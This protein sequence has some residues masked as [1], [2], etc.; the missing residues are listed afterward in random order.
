M[1]SVK[2][3]QL[4]SPI[5]CDEKYD[6]CHTVWHHCECAHCTNPFAT[7]LLWTHWC[8][9]HKK[10]TL[11]ANPPRF[12][13]TVNLAFRDNANPISKEE[14][15]VSPPWGKQSHYISNWRF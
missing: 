13:H 1:C 14:N 11:K 3:G 6:T 15:D 10:L 12:V 2:Q 7:S 8:Y 9:V 5:Q 4:M